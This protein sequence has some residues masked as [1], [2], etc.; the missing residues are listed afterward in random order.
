MGETILKEK[1]I[2]EV[3]INLF[4]K[5]ISNVYMNQ[6]CWGNIHPS[7][8]LDSGCSQTVCGQL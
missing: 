1:E 8:V 3:K 2:T 5:D 6:I 4:V 7:Y